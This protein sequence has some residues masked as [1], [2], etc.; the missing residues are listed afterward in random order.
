VII[1]QKTP[2]S[3]KGGLGGR[4]DLRLQRYIAARLGPIPGWSMG[5]G[6]D[7]DEWVTA[8]QLKE[9]HDNMHRHFG[10]SHFLGG[11]PAGPNRGTDHSQYLT[12]NQNLDYGSYEH[13]QPD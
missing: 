12:W 3:L 4:I 7:L 2:R 10:W 1:F 6:F 8:D 11:C 13:H 9:W 5:F